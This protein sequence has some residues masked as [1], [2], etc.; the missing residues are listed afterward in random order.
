MFNFNFLKNKKLNDKFYSIF[1][2]YFH[3][4]ITYR[5]L[6]RIQSNNFKK[7]EKFSNLI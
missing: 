6:I 2:A 5:Y 3:I 1:S 7:L 4:Y